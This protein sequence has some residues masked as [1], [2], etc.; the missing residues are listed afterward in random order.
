[1]VKIYCKKHETLKELKTL[2]SKTLSHLFRHK[3]LFFIYHFLCPF[4]Y[5]CYKSTKQFFLPNFLCKC[6]FSIPPQ[7]LFLYMQSRRKVEVHSGRLIWD[8][9]SINCEP[10]LLESYREKHKQFQLRYQQI[11]VV[12]SIWLLK[13][14][15]YFFLLSL[16]IYCNAGLG[17]SL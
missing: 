4:S 5:F 10:R 14:K 15:F 8:H 11:S 2:K 17:T 3:A 12:L 9:S 6:S 16:Q 7:G 1:M 13:I